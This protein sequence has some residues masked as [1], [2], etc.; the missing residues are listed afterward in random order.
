MQPGF[1]RA[2]AVCA[3]KGTERARQQEAGG[4]SGCGEQVRRGTAAGHGW[5]ILRA[6]ESVAVPASLTRWAAV[7]PPLPSLLTS[8]PSCF[9]SDR[10][11]DF[12]KLAEVTTVVTRNLN[13]IIDVNFYPVETARRSNMRHRPIGLGVQVCCG[14]GQ[15]QDARHSWSVRLQCCNFIRCRV[16]ATTCPYMPAAAPTAHPTPPAQGMADT[17]L[18]LGMPFDS[19]EAAEL[20]RQ[21]FETIY[22]AALRTSMQ[23]AKTEG[24]RVC[25][26]LGTLMVFSCHVSPATCPL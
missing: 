16:R 12:E 9:P 6:F 20:N 7:L 10:F 2:A 17:F 5:R 13:K 3:R 22:F 14:A 11:F 15:L 4:L 19:P 21:I 8:P 18:L 25:P 1:H 23:L 26:C 24:A